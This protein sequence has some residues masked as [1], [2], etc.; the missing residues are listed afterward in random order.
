[1]ADPDDPWRT[2]VLV[3]STSLSVLCG[4]LLLDHFTI[5][6]VV[7]EDEQTRCWAAGAGLATCT[8][9]AFLK[10][11]LHAD[12]LLS[13]VNDHILKA[14]VLSR[15]RVALNFHDAPLPAYAGLH[16]TS[17]A[18]V[19]REAEHG[20]SW[21]IVDSGIDTGAVVAQPR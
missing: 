9:P 21:H 6:L 3:G 2:V 10:L 16:A 18:M 8:Y 7:T 12:V 14:E 1:M 17:R 5:K 13:V 15:F 20:I 4:K 11:F 19:N